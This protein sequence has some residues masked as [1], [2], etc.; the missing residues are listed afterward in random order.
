MALD[1][2]VF[3]TRAKTA[4][5]YVAIMLIGLLWNE[6]SFFILISVVHFGCWHEYNKLSVLIDPTTRNNTLLDK[7]LFPIM[8]WGWMLMAASDS[9]TIGD[10]PINEVGDNLVRIGTVF[11]P[12]RFIENRAFKW[13]HLARSMGGVV[14]LSITLSLLVNLRSGWIWSHDSSDSLFSLA[15]G[16]FSGKLICILLVVGIWINDTM[17]YMVGSFIG[18][19]PLSSWSPKKTWEGTLGGIFLSAGL[20]SLVANLIWKANYE[21]FVI[22]LVC[23]IGGTIGD[24]AESRLKRLAGVK[25]SGSFMPG[26]GGFLDRFDSILFAAPL[27]WITCY[28]LNNYQ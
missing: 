21:V 6:W 18:K 13:R 24:L 5:I 1:K 23:A 19:T 12:F 2:K 22:S 14:Y 9:L 15:I 27:V 25:D 28:L 4:L 3:A 26:H 11:I 10:F 7:F 8:G 20:I 16:Q 17:A